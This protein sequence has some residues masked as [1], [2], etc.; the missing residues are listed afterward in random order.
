MSD[1]FP[2]Q[3]GLKQGDAL[4]PFLFNFSLEYAGLYVQ[5]NRDG[6]ELNGTHQP[7]VYGSTTMLIYWVK[8]QIKFAL[9]KKLKK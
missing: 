1:T 4:S 7:L 5:E 9:K 8:T 2:T 3:N 6:V